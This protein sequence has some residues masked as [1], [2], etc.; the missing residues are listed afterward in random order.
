MK[1]LDHLK[2]LETDEARAKFAADAE[3]TLGYLQ[4]IAYGFSKP[5]AK[6]A[7]S[8]SKASGGA[9]PTWELRPDYFDPPAEAANTDEPEQPKAA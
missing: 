2:G 1:L 6:L 4:Q 8:I 9:I 3:T 7:R 5:S